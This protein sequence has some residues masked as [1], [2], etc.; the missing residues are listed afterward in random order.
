MVA[1]EKSMQLDELISTIESAVTIAATKRLE[2]DNVMA[3]F[4]SEKGE[5]DLFESLEVTD[6]VDDPAT[7]MDI[8]VAKEIDPDASVGSAIRRRVEMEDLGRI[9][10]Q[11]V[12]QMIH[13]KGRE[14]EAHRLF[15][16]YSKRKGEV[17]T[18]TVIRKVDGGYLIDLGDVEA[19][20]PPPEQLMGERLERGRHVKVVIAEVA[21]GKREPL[22]DVSRTH[23]ALLRKLLEIE[24][25]EIA[26]GV[27]ENVALVR[28]PS[29]R[30]KVAVRSRKKDIDPVGACVGVRGGRI[31]PIVRELGGEKIDVFAWSDDP[32]K[33]IADA[34]T[35]AKNLRV[36]LSEKDRSADVIVQDDQLS[37]AIGKKGVNVR[38]AVKLTRWELDVMSQ[39]EYDEKK[40]RL[41]KFAPGREKGTGEPREEKPASGDEKGGYE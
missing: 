28:D 2:R 3:E 7:Q 13:K 11:S 41:K 19:T 29:G 20:L 14:A 34:L 38:L 9:A 6:H 27:V 32:K 18:G 4:D 30:S 5:F 33:L 26:E 25:P 35:P 1:D 22:V 24:T 16:D 31:Q 37:P 36:I 21:E 10:A 8:A 15:L 12:R 39:K 17:V 40:E 23:P